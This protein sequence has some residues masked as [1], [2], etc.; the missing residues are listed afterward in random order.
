MP[1]GHEGNNENALPRNEEVRCGEEN[2]G[3]VFLKSEIRQ[4][5]ADSVGL[6]IGQDST[7]PYSRQG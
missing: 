2:Q 3:K 6:G 1:L 4:Q 7:A 5:A